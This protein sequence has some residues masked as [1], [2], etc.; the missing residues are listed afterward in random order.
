M[1]DIRHERKV[2]EQRGIIE[3]S[4]LA[5]HKCSGLSSLKARMVM[6]PYIMISALHVCKS[7]EWN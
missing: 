4:A 6:W 5:L 2:K 7:C 1:G 3:Q